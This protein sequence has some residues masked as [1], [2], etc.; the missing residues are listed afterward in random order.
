MRLE[1]F[2]A[3]LA[4]RLFALML[5]GLASAQT[6]LD[7]AASLQGEIGLSA[8]RLKSLR[9]QNTKIA[10]LDQGFGNYQEGEASLPKNTKLVWLGEGPAQSPQ[11]HGLGLAR[12]LWGVLGRPSDGPLLY[13]VPTPGF[14]DLRRAVDYVIQE[15]IDIVLYSNNWEYGTNFD[16]TGLI[17]G[18]IQKALDRGVIWINSTGNYR[19]YVYTSDLVIDPKTGWVKVPGLGQTLR[20]RSLQDEAQVD[21]TLSWNDFSQDDSK[22]SNKDLDFELRDEFQNLISTADRIQDGGKSKGLPGYSA[23][24]RE[25]TPVGFTLSRGL[26]YLRIIPKSQNFDS[27]VD[28]FRVVVTTNNPQ[29]VQFLDAQGDDEV[30]TPGDMTDVITVGV[31]SSGRS[32]VSSTKPELWIRDGY[33][34]FSNGL[35]VGGSSTAAMLVAAGIVVMKSERTDLSRAHVREWIGKLPLDADGRRFFRLPSQVELGWLKP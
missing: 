15:K 17:P 25:R 32:G 9:L 6:R 23:Y 16:G 20:I 11:T 31:V 34:E 2:K 24:S 3:K 12:A 5:G 28:R 26:H 19:N 22:A 14:S 10:I 29:Q 8:A 33:L 4:L 13:L 7:N 35:E 18:I 21:I 27:S 1:R 30:L